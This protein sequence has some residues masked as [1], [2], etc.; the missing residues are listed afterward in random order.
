MKIKR[1]HT[2][3][4]N[5]VLIV[6]SMTVLA[7]VTGFSYKA[8]YCHNRLSGVAFFTELGIQKEA[9][10]GC[11]DDISHRNHQSETSGSLT[12]TKK[13]CCNN[14]S[15]FGK[16]NV[17]ASANYDITSVL[18]ITDLQVSALPTVSQLSFSEENISVFDFRFRP[19]PL[20]GRELVLFLSQQRIPLISYNC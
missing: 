7:G 18:K 20:S 2:Y 15:F 16:L 8:H 14:I 3:L 9:S 4:K 13:G 17:E 6:L 11:T 5:A 1:L 10:C 12:F 19:P